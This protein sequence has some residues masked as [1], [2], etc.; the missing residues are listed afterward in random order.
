V[1]EPEYRHKPAASAI[2]MSECRNWYTGQLEV[3]VPS[4]VCG[5]ESRFGHGTGMPEMAA[6][7]GTPRVNA[8]SVSSLAGASARPREHCPFMPF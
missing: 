3:L 5:F 1:Q 7:H 4:G 2:Y 6:R 8:D